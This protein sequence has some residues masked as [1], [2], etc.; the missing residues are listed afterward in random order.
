MTNT[1]NQ[2]ILNFNLKKWGSLIILA[3]AVAIVVID[4][5]VLNVSI[6]SI[7]RDLNTDLKNIQWA[8]TSYSLVLAALTIFGGKLGDIFGRKRMFIMG[9]LI[10]GIGSLVTALSPN[11][12]ILV[13]GWSLIEAI[14]AALMIPASSALIVS[15]YEG[16]DRGLA[17]GIY[18]VTAGIGAAAGPIL[19]G[20]L[21]STFSWR[22]VFGINLF[23]V[24][25]LVLGS[26]IVKN[27]AVP[28]KKVNLDYF[29]V[30]LSSLGLASLTYGIIESSTYGWIESKK[31]FEFAG[32][33]SN[34]GG[35]SISFYTILLGLILI[36]G[37][38]FWEIYLE[39]VKKLEP[40]ISMKIFLNRQ[41]SFGIGVITIL[42]A[43]FT[44]ILTFGVVL[45]YQYVFNLSA[46]ESGIGLIPLSLGSF[47]IA[48]LSAKIAEKISA[49]ITVQIGLVIA[50]IG[51]IVL[52][53][54]L[55][56]DATRITL[57]PALA[58]FGVGFGL[59]VAQIT[60]IILSAVP[61]SQAGQA[62]GI[63]GTIREVGRT[64]GS[65]LIGA[66]FIATFTS[67][68][69][70]NINSSLNIPNAVKSSIV[71]SFNSGETNLSSSNTNQPKYKFDE[72]IKS[73]VNQAIV[74][75]SKDSIK[76]TGFFI[77]LCLL[78]SFGL[79][80]KIVRGTAEKV[81]A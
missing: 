25:A 79:P 39:N 78:V 17:F 37:F 4:G 19:G 64:V 32:N 27:Y 43:G 80:N 47:I 65:A 11:V 22:W 5:T 62:S 16:K 72:E 9:A 55:T 26:R 48:P 57:I 73:D 81:E 18:G 68:V 41:F 51:C 12:N 56:L 49:K 20:F 28:S 34:L 33:F 44:G 69:T 10:F 60:N 14:G 23:V 15:N 36:A 42:F 1:A 52:F 71:S 6:S 45:F 35:L 58:I 59:I 30:V 74:E 54:S 13:L 38:V 31:A 53:N 66:V 77:L 70:N 75:G 63:N 29:G 50:I 76:Y 67:S 2:F 7:V 8:I 24:L 3:L 21:T 40:L 46:L 61:N